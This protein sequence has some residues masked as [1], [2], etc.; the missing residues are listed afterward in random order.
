MTYSEQPPERHGADDE[1]QNRDY[2]PSLFALTTQNQD[3]D[4][5]DPPPI[6]YTPQEIGEILKDLF[7]FLVSTFY[8]EATIE[9]P[10]PGGFTDLERDPEKSDFVHEV[11]RY[12]PR[13]EPKEHVKGG[14][15]FHYKSHLILSSDDILLPDYCEDQDMD[16]RD[17]F[18]IASGHESG[19][20]W[21]I[22]H[23]RRGM[24]QEE[25]GRMD[26]VGVFDMKEWIEDYKE[27][28]RSLKLIP[29]PGRETVECEHVPERGEG[30]EII[31]FE[32]IRAQKDVDGHPWRSDL[33]IHYIRQV[34]RQYGW[35]DAFR[36]DDCWEFLSGKMELMEEEDYHG[37]VWRWGGSL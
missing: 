12:M 10:P 4:G 35:P 34:Y 21:I 7:E 11:Y 13:F 28:Y 31:T 19:G 16:V 26:T 27:K 8:V 29:Y 23:T 1:S 32:E 24:I 30:A 9:L 22:L 14:I 18:Y 15:S 6:P 3:D 33:D 25:M 5:G 20:R 36:K 37:H 2:E 17:A